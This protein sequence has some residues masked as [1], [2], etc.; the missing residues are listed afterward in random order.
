MSVV[1]AD[2]GYWLALIEPRDTLRARALKLSRRFLAEE[3]ITTEM[4]LVEVLAGLSGRGQ[5]QRLTA[6]RHVQQL[7]TESAVEVIPQTSEQFRAALE[8]YADR[9][10]QSW[11]LTD[12]AS[13]LVME[14]RGINDALA[15]DRDF[16]Q[17]GFVPLLRA[18]SA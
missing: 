2:T 17:A 8:R 3:I 15:Y 9:P 14:A 12:C 6:A 7:I 4:V 13:F 10:D 16:E 1:F 11:S 5:A 18:D